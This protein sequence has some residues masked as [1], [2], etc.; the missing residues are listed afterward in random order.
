M[1]LFMIS[2][3]ASVTTCCQ[4]VSSKLNVALLTLR[5][6][7]SGTIMILQS[8]QTYLLRSLSC[9]GLY[10]FVGVYQLEYTQH[11][12]VGC[13]G[14]LFFHCVQQ[15]V[16]TCT[17][18]ELGHQQAGHTRAMMVSGEICL[19]FFLSSGNL[20]EYKKFGKY[21]FLLVIR[22]KKL[23]GFNYLEIHT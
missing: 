7:R 19:I 20:M 11:V 10:V 8:N 13:H 14:V 23:F 12:Y 16:L 2:Q 1:F 5:A 15:Q 6:C 4:Q 3:Q 22:I 18:K 21:H 9:A 17:I